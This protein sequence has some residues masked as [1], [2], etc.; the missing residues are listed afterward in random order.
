MTTGTKGTA[1]TQE[2]VIPEDGYYGLVLCGAA[3]HS[4]ND[5]TIQIMERCIDKGIISWAK[6]SGTDIDP[7]QI[8]SLSDLM[9][10]SLYVSNGKFFAG[11]N[12]IL[13]KDLDMKGSAAETSRIEWMPIG[14]R[15]ASN[16]S[17]G[18]NYFS[19]TFDGNG[20]TLSNLYINSTSKNYTGL[21][22]YLKSATIK[23]LGIIGE[24]SING[25]ANTGGFVGFASNQSAI[26][27]CYSSIATGQVKENG[28]GGCGGIAG[29]LFSSST[30]S[31]CYNKSNV[32]GGNFIGGIAGW[33]QDGSLIS[34]CFNTGKVESSSGQDIGGI[35]G[36]FSGS[37]I[38]YSYNTGGVKGGFNLGAL[39][40]ASYTGTIQNAYFN[41]TTSIQTKAT[42]YLSGTNNITATGM[43][44]AEMQDKLFVDKLNQGQSI[45][46]IPDG[47]P[48]SNAGYP[49]LQSNSAVKTI[50]LTA[51]PTEV[52]SYGASLN[53]YI[54]TGRDK[55]TTYG[56]EL[57]IKGSK[58]Y[59]KIQSVLNGVY[60]KSE[61]SE[62]KH[63]KQYTYRAYAITQTDT[64]YGDTINFTCPKCAVLSQ[65]TNK[66]GSYGKSTIIFEGNG[67][68]NATKISLTKTGYDTIKADTLVFTR[69]KCSA[70]FNFNQKAQ[71][72][73]NIVVNFGDTTVVL[74]DGLIIEAYKAPEVNVQ[75]VGSTYVRPNKYTYYTVH[76]YNIG[77]VNAYE[78]P[79]SINIISTNE[80][81]VDEGW[82]Y[83]SPP[84]E[85]DY[86][87]T[88]KDYSN[89][90]TDQQTGKVTKNLIPT[91]PMIP[92][93]G[94]GSLTFGVKMNKPTKIEVD[95]GAPMYFS[96]PN[97][98]IEQNQAFFDCF[99][100]IGQIAAEQ[101]WDLGISSINEVIPGA[102]CLN[103]FG[104]SFIKSQSQF[105][106]NKGVLDKP[107]V[108]NMVTNLAM[109][110]LSCAF[111][112]VP[113][114]E[115][116]K[117]LYKVSK[118]AMND[119]IYSTIASCNYAFNHNKKNNISAELVISIDP[120]DKIGYRSP[121]GSKYYN[122]NVNNFTYV[123][124]FENKSS[125]TAPAQEVY[126]TDTL[127][128][129]LFD[130]NSFKAGYIKIGKRIIQAP[131]NVQSNT[132]SI[133]MRPT[134]NLIT[135][136]ELTLDKNKGIAHWYFKSIDPKT[137]ALT[138]DALAGFLPPNDSIGSGE[139][140]VSF[141]IDLKSGLASDVA[142]KNKASI[143]FDTNAP[144]I[145][146]TW[147][148]IKDVIAP[149]SSMKQPEIANDSIVTLKWVGEDNNNGSGVY[150]YNVY[151]KKAG[152][153]YA[154]LLTNT[155][156]NSIDFKFKKDTEYYFY[157]T[158]KDSAGNEEVKTNVPDIT[159]KSN[160]VNAIISKKWNDVLVC[161]NSEKLFS[162][163]QWYKNDV[164]LTGETKQYYQET[165]GLNG[166]YYVKVITTDGK[167]G[168]S[169]TINVTTSAKSIRAYPNPAADNQSFQLEIKATE[170]DLKEAHLT[171][172]SLSG[173]IVLQDN[174]LQ[175]QMLLNGLPKGCYIIHVRLTNGEQL[176]E[177]LM[178]N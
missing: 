58:Q 71:G 85:V 124:N 145:T 6:G 110:G 139:G 151:A 162:S 10:L 166:S 121:S 109:A 136:V 86:L 89:V 117:K 168:V 38:R 118:L 19:G 169:N 112:F 48:Q 149:L 21:F 173:Q 177:K 96:N 92:P 108:G 67:F 47:S 60:L 146:P 82:E 66:V 57:K 116:I 178:V 133:D 70:L 143:V 72:N 35:V 106:A 152:E 28:A 130:V 49:V 156:Q 129:N 98:D 160:S 20:F 142:V 170:T 30:V 91:I 122:V 174:N 159:F 15:D 120:N 157:V 22:G 155:T 128:T 4:S 111:S 104:K 138:T 24:C 101:L 113:G 64:L 18:T 107:L 33:V 11:N 148:N 32:A 54:Y 77:N 75:L 3:D 36:H 37:I 163:Y 94:E 119:K 83:S 56:F 115:L 164:A 100:G 102:S 80:T 137:N 147:S 23:N 17:V 62:L 74:K 59:T 16:N 172:L 153:A 154:S 79:I 125:A 90:T 42:G 43:T 27:N 87:P 25:G 131:M 132:W 55:A 73:W 84:A 158:A 81:D 50:V 52:Y 31:N 76:Y 150:Q 140:S 40:G 13:M 99:S 135:T 5:Y 167:T 69:N 12:F 14:G 29:A 45:V 39:V 176:N 63:G 51:Y 165:G 8:S 2:V 171:I 1:L 46:W 9:K 103:S 53:G 144:I 114:D 126:I 127:D 93:N 44:T 95:A 26:T 161:N 123:I 78:V 141:S 65:S 175:P 88:K 68:S 41:K 97:G 7:W 34:N 105:A 134:M 61:T